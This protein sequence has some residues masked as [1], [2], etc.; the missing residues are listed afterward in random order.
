MK[1]QPAVKTTTTN[2]HVLETL[3]TACF[4]QGPASVVCD[5]EQ[6]KLFY[7][8]GQPAFATPKQ[9]QSRE[10]NRENEVEWTRKVEIR[11]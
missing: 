8:A 2:L 7:S 3:Y 9:G 6:G 1:I 11:K 5:D 4:Q 10:R